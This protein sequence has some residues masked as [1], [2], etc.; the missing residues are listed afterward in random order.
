MDQDLQIVL[1]EWRRLGNKE[2]DAGIEEIEWYVSHIEDL[3]AHGLNH[4][5]DLYNA[6][7]NKVVLL[8]PSVPDTPEISDRRSSHT[9]SHY[10]GA[11][12][13]AKAAS[14][15]PKKR[16]TPKKEVRGLKLTIF[17]TA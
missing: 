3:N 11:K 14:A 5:A 15:Q 7:L 10:G 13:K 2:V 1:D 4:L 6:T 8:R 17:F 9:R 16:A 12:P